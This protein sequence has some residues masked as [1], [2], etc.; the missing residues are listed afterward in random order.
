MSWRSSWRAQALAMVI[1]GL[2]SFRFVVVSIGLSIQGVSPA[3]TY[4]ASTFWYILVDFFDFSLQIPPLDKE[5]E[6][7]YVGIRAS[8][9][10][11]Y[12]TSMLHTMP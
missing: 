11:R 8:S 10:F 3:R 5:S 9:L 2:F 6:N 12:R 1:A 4:A 7:R